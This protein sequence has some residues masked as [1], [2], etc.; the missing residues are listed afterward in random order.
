M[1]RTA[2]AQARAPAPAK[3]A[4][5]APAHPAPAPQG[6]R[7]GIPL[8]GAGHGAPQGAPAATVPPTYPSGHPL[9]SWRALNANL[10]SLSEKQAWELLETERAGHCRVQLI[11]RLYGRANRLRAYRERKEMLA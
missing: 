5:A 8:Q 6:T 7:P 2:T 1:T 9:E 4:S 11:L 10:N 3:P